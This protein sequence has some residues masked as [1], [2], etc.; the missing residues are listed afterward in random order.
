MKVLT[1]DEDARPFGLDSQL[2]M[3][4]LFVKGVHADRFRGRQ[5]GMG[6]Y[7]RV[8]F[9]DDISCRIERFKRQT[10]QREVLIRN[11]DAT[12]GKIEEGSG[13]P[14]LEQIHRAFVGH[15]FDTGSQLDGSFR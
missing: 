15:G 1:D 10:L 11:G 7:A 4:S 8:S 9:Q 6:G 13:V 5:L 2:N 3:A 12:A 14:I